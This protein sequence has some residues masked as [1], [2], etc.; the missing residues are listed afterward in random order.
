MGNKKEMFERYNM[1]DHG[2]KPSLF[3]FDPKND[4]V[5]VFVYRNNKFPYPYTITNTKDGS[6]I[7]THQGFFLKDFIRELDVFLQ[8]NKLPYKIVEE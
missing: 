4:I 6:D 5:D 7:W 8:K 2:D 3:E 1:T